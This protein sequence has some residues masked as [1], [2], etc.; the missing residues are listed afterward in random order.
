MHSDIDIKEKS[1]D[2]DL[3]E[4]QEPQILDDFPHSGEEENK[5]ETLNE[6][7]LAMDAEVP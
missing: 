2:Q 4:Q 1:S 6:N 3:N 7:L 5:E